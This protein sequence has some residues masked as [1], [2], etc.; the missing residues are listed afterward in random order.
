[1]LGGGQYSGG[2]NGSSPRFSTSADSEAED[3]ISAVPQ[4]TL[5]RGVASPGGVNLFA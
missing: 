4:I 3:A 2:G 1:M 5:Y